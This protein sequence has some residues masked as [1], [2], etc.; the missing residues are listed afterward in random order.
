MN[1][2][3]LLFP[4]GDD[5]DSYSKKVSNEEFKAFIKSNSKDF[6]SFKTSLLYEE[7][8]NDPIRRADLIKDIVESIS[9]IPDA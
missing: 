2:R 9:V 3:V 8:K 1:V 6:I 7:V 4:N 5:P